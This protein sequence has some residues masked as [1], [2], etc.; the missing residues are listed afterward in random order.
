MKLAWDM[1]SKLFSIHF[2]QLTLILAVLCRF[3]RWF[4]QMGIFCQGRIQTD[5]TDANASVGIFRAYNFEEN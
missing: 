1:M 5:A 3:L 4:L 2:K